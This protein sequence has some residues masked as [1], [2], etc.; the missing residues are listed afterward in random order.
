MST[1]VVTRVDAISSW[2]R[3]GLVLALM[4]FGLVGLR[5]AAVVTD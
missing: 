4:C 3:A 2:G 5:Q 1:P